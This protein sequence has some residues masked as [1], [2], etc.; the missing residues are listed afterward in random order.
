MNEET[1]FWL[2]P[3]TVLW[4]LYLIVTTQAKAKKVI[5]KFVELLGVEADI[6]ELKVYK[7]GRIHWEVEITTK[8]SG[9][10]PADRLLEIMSLCHDKLAPR[11]LI[12]GPWQEDDW[13]GVAGWAGVRGLRIQGVADVYFEANF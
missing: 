11:W 8:L 13:W 2:Q 9:K 5:A 6:G 10:T 1:V 7:K 12:T 4:E 3:M